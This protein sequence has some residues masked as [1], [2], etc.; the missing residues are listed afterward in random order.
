MATYQKRGGSWRAIV[1]KKNTKTTTRTFDL[2]AEAVKWATA[3]EA[4][5]DAGYDIERARETAQVEVAAP[6]AATLMSRYSEDI[7]PKNRGTRSEQ[8]RLSM[9][10]RRFPLF[11]RP[12]SRITGADMADW[13][14]QRLTEVG[15]GT[16]RRELGLLSA[17]FKIAI[18]E[19]RIGM[20]VNPCHLVVWPRNPRPRTQRVPVEARDQLIARLGWNGVHRPATTEQWSAMALCF[21]LETA[22]RKGE[23]LSLQ[24][25][26]I[27]FEERFAHLDITKNG[28]ERD[29]PLSRPAMD[30]LSIAGHGAPGEQIF[31][32]SAGRLDAI[33]R[34][35]RIDL[36]LTHIRFHDARREATTKI[37]AKMSNVLE[38]SAVTGHKTLNMLKIYYKPKPSTL[39]DK[40][41]GVTPQPRPQHTL[42]PEPCSGET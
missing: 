40:L 25:R 26:D 1:R 39:A 17:V 33:M 28:D 36:G 32:V 16:V 18:K 14:D 24:W 37:A 31:K 6:S 20:T 35:A 27:N 2:R 21:A 22:M 38:L 19:W 3:L 9:L 15:P 5:I 7:S 11:Q 13:R 10:A 12:A 30:L 4:Q 41:D 29:V 23:I 34:A 8:I 42:P